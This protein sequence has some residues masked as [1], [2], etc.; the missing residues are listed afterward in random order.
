MERK[1]A[2]GGGLF[3][4]IYMDVIRSKIQFPLATGTFSI[5]FLYYILRGLEDV[6]LVQ[7]IIAFGTCDSLR[8]P[9]NPF[10]G[11]RNNIIEFFNL[12][13]SRREKPYIPHVTSL[14]P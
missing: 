14:F 1:E 4:R 3:T 2:L 6:T 9:I 10:R 12:S 11:Y 7:K 8:Q 5:E 13:D